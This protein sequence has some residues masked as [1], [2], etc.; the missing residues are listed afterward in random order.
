MPKRLLLLLQLLRFYASTHC[1]TALDEAGTNASTCTSA[2]A[3]AT[4]FFITC[5]RLPFLTC[6][7]CTGA[8][9]IFIMCCQNLDRQGG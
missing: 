3:E 7:L 2:R 8:R 5:S 9:A 6:S 1:P 4:A